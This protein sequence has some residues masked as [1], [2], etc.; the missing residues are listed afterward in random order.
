[1]SL[2]ILV[3]VYI[4]SNDLALAAAIREGARGR[5]DVFHVNTWEDTKPSAMS[6]TMQLEIGLGW[7]ERSRRG[8]EI[9]IAQEI[10]EAL[11]IAGY[12]RDIDVRTLDL[13]EAQWF[14]REEVAHLRSVA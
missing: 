14:T 9:A 7:Q 12:R 5:V 2:S 10:I 6:I 11:R 1:M 4:K 3:K 13:D 8:T